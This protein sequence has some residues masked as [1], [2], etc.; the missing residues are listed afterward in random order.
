VSDSDEL[1]ASHKEA[2][3]KLVISRKGT[4]VASEL[5]AAHTRD[6]TDARTA[7]HKIVSSLMFLGKQGLALRGH[8]DASANFNNLLELRASDSDQLRGWLNRSG[9]K[10]TSHEIQNEI[11]RELAHSVLRTL[12]NEL[13]AAKYY[14]IVMDEASDI[15][16]KEQVSVCF[17]YV[18]PDLEVHETFMG[19]YETAATDAGTLFALISDSLVRFNMKLD[20]CRGQC[21][22]GLPTWQVMCPGFNAEFLISSRKRYIS[23]A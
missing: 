15:S 12:N 5:S 7:L 9:Y 17:R 10:W 8:T 22:D 11:V 20:N 16:G 23:T 2:V 4:N 19:F 3:M 13:L 1:S 18:L 14:A 21:F 6:R